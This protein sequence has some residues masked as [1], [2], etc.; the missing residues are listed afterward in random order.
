MAQ[1]QF[2]RT[3]MLL[4]SEGMEKLKFLKIAIFGIGGVGSFV[5]EGLA[6][7]G[8]FNI[9]LFDDDN[10][11]LTNINR[12][13][14]ATT[15]TIGKDKV[16]MM[17]QRILDINPRANVEANVCFFGKDT[18]N[19]KFDKY[20]YIIDAVDTV[21]SK[22]LLVEK[23]KENNINIISCMGTGNK[24]DPTKFEVADIYKT[25]VCPLA[26]VM[27][28]E[29]KNRKIKNLKVVFSKE[30]PLIPDDHNGKLNCKFNCICPPGAAAHCV[31]RRQVPG[32]VSFVPSVAAMIIVGEVVKDIVYNNTLKESPQNII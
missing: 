22:I 6:R 8:V 24:L 25:S 18:E 23:A 16:E 31:I 20:D 30:K 21:S 28:K 17:K 10:I 13:I 4:G 19:I 27:R 2:S 32:S 12:Q 15:K 3:Q 29:L 7:S 1:N 11:C 5:A 9:S 26:R 14:M